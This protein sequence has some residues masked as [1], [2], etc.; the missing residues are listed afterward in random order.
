MDAKVRRVLLVDDDARFLEALEALLADDPAVAVVGTAHDGAEA[1]RLVAELRPDVVTM[2]IDM[3]VLDGVEATR[4]IAAEFPD[5][6]VVTITA[7]T[8]P[9]RIEEA[10]A[11]GASGHV[12]KS[13]VAEQL[14]A[15]IHAACAAAVGRRAA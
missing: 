10:R 15:A 3:P 11:A 12:S 7:S 5:V 13:R 9:E 4:A 14:P 2:D 6:C 1:L 8:S